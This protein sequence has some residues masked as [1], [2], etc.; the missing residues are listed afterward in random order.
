MKNVELIFVPQTSKGHLIP[1]LEFAKRLVDHNSRIL[2]TVVFVKSPFDSFANAYI[3][4]VKASKPDRFKFIDV[5]LIVDHH[6]Q[7]FEDHVLDLV[8][9]HLPLLKNAV[10]DISSEVRK[11]V[12]EMAKI[13]RKAIVNGGSSFLSIQKLIDDMIELIFVPQTSKGHLIPILDFAKR[14]VDHDDRISTTVVFVKSPSDSS[15]DA[16]I[17]S[18]KISKLD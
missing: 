10:T 8:E 6:R 7:S 16:Y 13:A 17:E 5:P 2:I 14:L 18:V 4:S 3:D 11:K 9:T 1:I 15:T 12:K